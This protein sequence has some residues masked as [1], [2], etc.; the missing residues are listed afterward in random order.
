MRAV[1]LW[2]GEQV[3]QEEVSEWCRETP[4]GCWLDEAM[5]SLRLEGFDVEELIDDAEERIRAAIADSE[6][7]QPV[8]VTLKVPLLN[9]P[10]DHAVVLVGIRQQA[11]ENGQSEIVEFMD[12]LTGQIEQDATG[13]LWQYW[14]FA[15]RR[16]FILRP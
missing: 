5:E 15:G 6:E 9:A 11:E 14:D 4:G 13:M 1:L 3:T 8:I 16:A 2:Y 12:P 7:P 10:R